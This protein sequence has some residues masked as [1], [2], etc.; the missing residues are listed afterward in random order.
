MDLATQTDRR[1][2]DAGIGPDDLALRRIRAWNRGAWARA[3]ER[4]RGGESGGFHGRNGG[5]V[6]T[7]GARNAG[8]G[9]QGCDLH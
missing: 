2:R 1:L 9:A 4:G 6:A 7:M 5:G 3:W 8:G